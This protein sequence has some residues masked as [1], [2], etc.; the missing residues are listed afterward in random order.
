MNDTVNSINTIYDEDYLDNKE[1]SSWRKWMKSNL[2]QP[3]DQD[4]YLLMKE[5][6]RKM[7]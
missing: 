5:M 3:N 6:I 4:L 1:A 7:H 2:K